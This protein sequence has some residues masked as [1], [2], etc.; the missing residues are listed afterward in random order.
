LILAAAVLAVVGAGGVSLAYVVSYNPPLTPAGYWGPAPGSVN[1]VAGPASGPST[2]GRVIGPAR[3]EVQ[4]VF[5]IRSDG[6]FDVR[7]DRIDL[8]QYV[9]AA[10]WSE[11]HLSPGGSISGDDRPWRAFPSKLPA[12]GQIRILVTIRQPD[13]TINSNK[14]S[15]VQHVTV[16]WHALGIGHS[17]PI[18]IGIGEQIDLCP[19]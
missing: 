8:N 1:R 10:Q 14:G 19:I 7:V 2:H 5:G 16:H 9:V 12:H 6:R 4:I 18:D 15:V 17:T 11:Y 13:C 3:T